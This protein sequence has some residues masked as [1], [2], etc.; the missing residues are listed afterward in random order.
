MKESS[1]G[2]LITV[3]YCENINIIMM[4]NFLLAVKC[5]GGLFLPYIK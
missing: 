4:Q 2:F 3:K 5:C 1:I